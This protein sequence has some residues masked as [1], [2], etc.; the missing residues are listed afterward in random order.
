MRQTGPEATRTA[1][2][3]AGDELSALLHDLVGA[4]HAGLRTRLHGL[5]ARLHDEELPA[6]PVL[7]PLDVHR[8]AIVA[9]DC[10]RGVGKLQNLRIGENEAGA[11]FERGWNVARRLLAFVRV[12]HF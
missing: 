9:L 5:R 11:L 1:N 4:L 3:E 7:R 8:A 6:S 10:A 2:A 12:D